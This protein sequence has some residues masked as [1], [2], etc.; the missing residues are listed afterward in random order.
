MATILLVEDDMF[1][2]QMLTDLLTMEGYEVTGAF[3]GTE[4][5]MWFGHK[6]FD[7]VILDLMLPGKTGEEVLVEL[8]KS[9]SV[10]VIVL[11]AVATKE[12]TVSLLRAGANDYLAKPFDNEELLARLEV[13]LRGVKNAVPANKTMYKDLSLDTNR[14]EALIGTVPL[15]LSKREF[16]ILECLV[17]HPQKVFTKNNLYQSVWGDEFYGDENTVNVHISKIRQKLAKVNPDGSYIQT[18]WGIG[19]KMCD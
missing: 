11:T 19:F 7:L 13:Q 3:S 5:L 17:S 1:I 2:H 14:Y 4:A 8:R 18:V 10:P 9:S 16:Q 12:S 15:G 6:P